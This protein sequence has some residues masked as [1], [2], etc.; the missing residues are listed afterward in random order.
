M[1]A[2]E[3]THQIPWT[4][5]A[6]LVAAAASIIGV[7]LHVRH[8]DRSRNQTALADIARHRIEWIERLRQSI[9]DF[10]A[11]TTEYHLLLQQ[12]NEKKAQECFEKVRK[13]FGYLSLL[14]NSEDPD[15]KEILDRCQIFMST[16]T[17]EYEGNPGGWSGFHTAL[18]QG[19]GTKVIS[20]V[21]RQA[22]DEIRGKTA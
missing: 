5:I 1:T 22:K 18:V 2:A 13:L 17:G 3:T 15:Q 11:Y 4:L 21:W 6:A 10:N 8:A 19:S 20:T 16:P 12:N 9:S 14:L 7:L